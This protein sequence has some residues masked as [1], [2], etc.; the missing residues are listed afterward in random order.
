MKHPTHPT[1]FT[2]FLFRLTWS[3]FTKRQCGTHCIHLFHT[4]INVIT[5]ASAVIW[6]SWKKMGWV[7]MCGEWVEAE[8]WFSGLKLTSLDN[9]YFGKLVQSYRSINAMM[10]SEAA[11][12][13]ALEKQDAWT[14]W[15]NYFCILWMKFMLIVFL[16]LLKKQ[17][18]LHNFISTTVDLPSCRK[19]ELKQEFAAQIKT[20]RESPHSYQ[21]VL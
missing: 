3:H 21:L 5:W 20:H 11:R 10:S 16:L 17:I 15:T 13:K 9:P 1:H 18:A 14:L 7:S 2:S 19:F 4:F 6:H 12:L 8:S